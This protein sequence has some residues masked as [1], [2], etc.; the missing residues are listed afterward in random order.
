MVE[1]EFYDP[2]GNL[3][4]TQ[5]HAFRLDSLNGKRIGILT[6]EQ[7]QAERTL[8]LLKT[9]ME[10]DFPDIEV[11]PLDTFP[12]GEHA[13]GAELTIQ[14]VK[15]SGAD[16][17]IIGNAACG[18]CSTALGR[19]AAKLESANIPTVLLGRSDFLGVVKNAVTGMGF[20]APM[21]IV[22]F[23]VDLFLPGSE[24]SPVEARKQEFYEGLTSWRFTP[25]YMASDMTPLISVTGVRLRRSAEQG[26]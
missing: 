20:P 13:V 18:S 17:I 6:G 11:L 15:E 22:D 7:W 14:Q 2:S 26:E 24:L 4:I 3:E 10:A 1:L 8:P 9:M 16:G 5:R 21:P 25:N 12:G 23:P 19:A